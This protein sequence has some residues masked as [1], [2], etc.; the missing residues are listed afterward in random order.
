MQNGADDRIV[1]SSGVSDGV[2]AEVPDIT[3][4]RCGIID[5]GRDLG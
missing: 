1:F 2:G 3:E 5:S 4:A